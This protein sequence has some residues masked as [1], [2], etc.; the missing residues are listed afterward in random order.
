MS[1]L[2]GSEKHENGITRRKFIAE[3]T[4]SKAETDPREIVKRRYK[5]ASERDKK[6]KNAERSE[7]TR[8]RQARAKRQGRDPSR[9]DWSEMDQRG[10]PALSFE[11]GDRNRPRHLE[12][13]RRKPSDQERKRL[14]SK[15]ATEFSRIYTRYRKA[16]E[17]RTRAYSDYEV[18]RG[19]RKYAAEAGMWCLIKG[20]TPRRV[21]E[22]WDEN[23]K[24]FADGSMLVPP[25]SFLRAPANIDRVACSAISRPSK[26]GRHE[27]RGKPVGIPR[28]PRKP[29]GG[30][31]FSDTDGLDVRLRPAL[32]DAGFDTQDYND[33]FLMTIQKN[34]I[35]IASGKHVFM[36]AGKA[37][38]MAKWAAEHLYAD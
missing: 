9:I 16:A 30:N 35:S 3:E 1:S 38:E 33:R 18:E 25:L 31:S 17:R 34:A 36:G 20:V 5:E 27:P 12:V 23:I 29:F 24:T 28:D 26:R 37:K 21:L 14:M 22:Y 7:A 10:Q 19:E 8:Q 6:R 4:Y 11:P 15:I 2:T 13:L 32:Q